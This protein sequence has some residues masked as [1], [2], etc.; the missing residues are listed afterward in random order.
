MEK[1]TADPLIKDLDILQPESGYRFSMDP[2]LLA[3]HIH[4]MPHERILDI[5]CG[6]GVMPLILANN[7]L[8]VQVIGVEI[9]RELSAF[10]VTNINNN[11]LAHRITLLNE[12]IRHVFPA[13][14]GGAVDRIISNPPYK[15]ASS[16][17]INPD[18]QKA[19][20]RHDISL[21]LDTLFSCAARLLKPKGTIT[22][23]F[24]AGRLQDIS[25]RMSA[26]A[27]GL[28][29]LKCIHTRKDRP[30]K[31]VLVSGKKNGKQPCRILPPL[32][33][34]DPPGRPAKSDSRPFAQDKS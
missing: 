3:S 14:L 8:T 4:P 6:C 22:I 18:P 7:H 34:Q 23:V 25:D 28:E 9:Q 32:I 29:C 31:R 12:D 5:G 20:A 16:G 13:D 1:Y 33:I 27:F 2:V 10:A 15:K 17:R 30:A 26:H 24:P 11:H 19:M 21:D